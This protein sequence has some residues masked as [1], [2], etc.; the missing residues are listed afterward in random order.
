MT[1]VT[2]TSLS[3][4]ITASQ[5]DTNFSDVVS[6]ASS[7]G[8]EQLSGGITA[9]KLTDRYSVTYDTLHLVPLM[10]ATA[11]SA[12]LGTT[13]AF[14]MTAAQKVLLMTWQPIMKAGMEAY[15]SSIV[16]SGLDVANNPGISFYLNGTSAGG[17]LLGGTTITLAASNTL[18]TLGQTDP[19][20]NP[21]LA[22]SNGDYLSIYA[23]DAG[24]AA[25]TLRGVTAT[26]CMKYVL[27]A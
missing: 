17:S 22:F 5:L 21:L 14:T 7:V 6:I 13:T 26:I 11:G 19:I 4:T 10:A 18:Y 15:L 20:A 3:G 25:S 16:V 12:N 23:V 1:S 2:F 8:N 27:Q 9:D 24:A